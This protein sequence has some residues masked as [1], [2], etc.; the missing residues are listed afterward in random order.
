MQ[1]M[2]TRLTRFATITA[3]VCMLLPAFGSEG[4]G[5]G[6]GNLPPPP[7]TPTSAHII[8]HHGAPN[9]LVTLPSAFCK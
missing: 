4:G 7:P 6:G 9:S 1:K 5:V 2:S 8:G 3:F